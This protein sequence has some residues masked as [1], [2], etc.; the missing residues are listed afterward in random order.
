M[1]NRR[2]RVGYEKG[3]LVMRALEDQLGQDVLIRCL[4]AFVER[5]HR[6]DAAEWSDFAAVVNKE[7]GQDYGWFFAEWVGRAGMPS[8]RLTNVATTDDGTGRWVEADIVQEGAP[9]RM[10]M[11]VRLE[12]QDGTVTDSVTDVHG[13]TTHIRVRTTG[14][15]ARLS[16]DP[17]GKLPLAEPAHQP[18]HTDTAVYEWPPK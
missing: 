4:H 8:V 1:D 12:Q 15:P 17:E 3:K 5:H 2:E 13:A 6:G 16:L 14:A 7:T 18:L 10:K 9:Y 11:A